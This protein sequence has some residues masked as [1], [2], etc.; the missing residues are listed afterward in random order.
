MT[1]DAA[2][3]SAQDR[4][5]GAA[6]VEPRMELFID[7]RDVNRAHRL[8]RRI[9]EGVV[10]VAWCRWPAIVGRRTLAA[11]KPECVCL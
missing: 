9:C 4:V 8:S 6:A 3:P 1:T 5:A 10:W 11:P 2:Q 7:G